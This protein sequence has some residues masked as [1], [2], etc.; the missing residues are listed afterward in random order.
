[1]EIQAGQEKKSLE[2]ELKS[3]ETMLKDKEKAVKYT[4]NELHKVSISL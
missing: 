2:N 4:K 1:M 3:R